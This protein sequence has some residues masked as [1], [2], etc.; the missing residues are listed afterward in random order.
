MKVIFLDIDGVL[1][2]VDWAKRNASKDKVGFMSM[3][4]RHAGQIDPDALWRLIKI[5]NKTDA[6][7]VISSTW[8]LLHSIS[9]IDSIFQDL[10]WLGGAP[11][12]GRTPS[13]N[14]AP[15]GLEIHTWLQDNPHVSKFIIIDD[16]SDMLDDQM[17]NFVHTSWEHGLLDSHV[18]KAIGILNG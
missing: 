14:N 16:D 13:L 11:I 4:D 6:K 17:D 10:G 7:I 12:I 3:F 2:S 18:D 1:N 8:R 15:R 5:V 9:E